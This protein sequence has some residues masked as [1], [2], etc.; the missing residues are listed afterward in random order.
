MT[1]DMLGRAVR[2]AESATLAAADSGE[3]GSVDLLVELAGLGKELA[4]AGRLE[5]SGRV[6][7]SALRPPQTEL[8]SPQR[9]EAV[10]WYARVSRLLGRY[11][12]S[13]AVLCEGIALLEHEAALPCAARQGGTT[14]GT[15][16]GA[17]D[18]SASGFTAGLTLELSAAALSSGGVDPGLDRRLAGTVRHADPV[19]RAQ[20]LAQQ[21]IVRIGRRRPDD[22]LVPAHTAAELVDACAYEELA[23]RLE[24]LY[25]V[26]ESERLLGLLDR[27]AEHFVR[28][29][30]VAGPGAQH[31]LRPFAEVGL[32]R[33]RLQEG[34][35]EAAARCRDSAEELASRCGSA[36]MRAAALTLRS[37]VFLASGDPSGAAEAAKRALG[38]A[39]PFADIWARQARRSLALAVEALGGGRRKPVAAPGASRRPTVPA[40]AQPG[41]VLNTLSRREMEIAQLVSEGRTNQQIAHALGLSPKTVETYMARIFTKLGIG[42]RTQVAHL[43][44]LTS[45]AV[46][47]EGR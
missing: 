21:A 5:E 27:S 16:R 19:V 47:R 23:G 34:D 14:R 33:V 15:S 39:A 17:A 29:I 44:G 20:G 6:L 18:G 12:R 38:L 22:A 30:D 2:A 28:V 35:V 37:Q 43:V 32:G 3:P 46:Q 36:P 8:P 10:E 26:A 7:W 45:E 42:S 9:A 25:W 1:T 11:A 41:G 31:Y 40:A 13:R 24:T 4:I